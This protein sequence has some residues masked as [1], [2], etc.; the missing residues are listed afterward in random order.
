MIVLGSDLA[1]Q[2][3]TSLFLMIAGSAESGNRNGSGTQSLDTSGN[4]NLPTAGSPYG[5][6]LPGGLR[7]APSGHTVVL[8]RDSV[9]LKPTIGSIQQTT[10]CD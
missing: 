9:D 5:N 8:L 10:P 6:A 2:G 3:W 4:G 7:M 1:S